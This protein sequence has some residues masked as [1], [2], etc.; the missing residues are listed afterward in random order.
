MVWKIVKPW[1]APRVM[2]KIEILGEVK[3]GSPAL[4]ALIDADQLPTYLGGSCEC[5][6]SKDCPHAPGQ[7]MRDFLRVTEIGRAAFD[8]EQ[9]RPARKLGFGNV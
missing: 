5:K 3:E 2:S 8:K 4:L 7:L 1:L 6:M 9:T